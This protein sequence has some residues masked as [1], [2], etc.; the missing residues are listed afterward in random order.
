MIYRSTLYIR[1][2]LLSHSR[3]FIHNAAMYPDSPGQFSAGGVW[4]G[5]PSAAGGW[6]PCQ[7]SSGSP[8]AGAAGAGLQSRGLPSP[9][10]TRIRAHVKLLVTQTITHLELVELGHVVEDGEDDDG[11]HVEVEGVLMHHLPSRHVSHVCWS[12]GRAQYSKVSYTVAICNRCMVL[13]TRIPIFTSTFLHCWTSLTC[14]MT[15]ITSQ[16]D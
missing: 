3:H 10:A 14:L 1:R 11:D 5:A 7:R 15:T 13:R 12:E 6:P 16:S 8:A 2:G 9:G 4:R